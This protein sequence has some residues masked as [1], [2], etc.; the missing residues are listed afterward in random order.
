M[1]NIGKIDKIVFEDF[2]NLNVSFLDQKLNNNISKNEVFAPSEMFKYLKIKKK[3]NILYLTQNKKHY[4]ADVSISL[5]YE[6]EFLDFIN[7]KVLISKDLKYSTFHFQNIKKIFLSNSRVHSDSFF[8]EEAN[9]VLRTSSIF[10][11]KSLLSKKININSDGN[12][13][14]KAKEGYANTTILQVS[15]HSKIILEKDFFTSELIKSEIFSHSMARANVLDS[16]SCKISND[17]M[18][19]NK[20]ILFGNPSIEISDIIKPHRY[21]RPEFNLPK[22]YSKVLEYKNKLSV[23]DELIKKS[24]SSGFLHMPPEIKEIHNNALLGVSEEDKL[25]F[26]AISKNYESMNDQVIDAKKVIEI[27]ENHKK[28]IVEKY[29]E[30]TKL[31]INKY[32]YQDSNVF[33]NTLSILEYDYPTD[34]ICSKNRESVINMIVKIIDDNVKLNRKQKA[35]IKKITTLFNIKTNKQKTLKFKY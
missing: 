13:M 32:S 3:K 34:H 6:P 27:I 28:I 14:F 12:S 35:N 19:K 11:I 18:N 33:N 29:K 25:F 16:F 17:N 30:T 15:D 22:Q 9:I 24:I 8:N 26:L 31:E 1:F 21:K 10:N 4:D 7:S 20:F 23:N 5:S 2:K